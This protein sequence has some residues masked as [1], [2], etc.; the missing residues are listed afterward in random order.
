MPLSPIQIEALVTANAAA[1]DLTLAPAHRPGVLTYFALAAAM[2]E[3]VTGFDLGPHDESGSVF[4]PVAPPFAS[5]V[6]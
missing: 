1:L 5:K 6:E 4:L 2:A 3:L